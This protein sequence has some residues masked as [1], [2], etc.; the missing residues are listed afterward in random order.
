MLLKGQDASAMLGERVT[1]EWPSGG[2]QKS[3]VTEC[4]AC[5]LEYENL[6]AIS[7]VEN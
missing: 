2:A 3:S 5:E 1:I 6:A 7:V 4:A